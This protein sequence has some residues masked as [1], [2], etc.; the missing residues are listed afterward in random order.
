MSTRGFVGYRYK[1][2]IH[3]WYNHSDSYP[4]GL[5]RDVLEKFMKHTRSQLST[6]FLKHLSL[7]TIERG[8]FDAGGGSKCLESR[9]VMDAAWDGKGIIR[10]EDGGEFYKDG[11]YCEYSYIFDLDAPKKTL[12]LFSGFG[13]KPSKG[14]ED[15]FEDGAPERAGGRPKRFY[16][17]AHR[18]LTDESDR[19][20]IMFTI[21]SAR[22]ERVAVVE[23]LLTC[24]REKLPLLMNAVKNVP[25]SIRDGVQAIYEL[26]MKGVEFNVVFSTRG[27]KVLA[28]IKQGDS[29]NS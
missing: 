5:G 23:R 19:E 6:F 3:G 18:P 11:L 29:N 22:M 24:S 26:R 2:K 27:E 16:V 7:E 21:L 8:P 1:G 20:D 13:R 9:D 14:Y 12:L 25:E 17:Q 10:V 15:W 4:D 28:A